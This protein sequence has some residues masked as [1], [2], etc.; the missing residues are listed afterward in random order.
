MGP[1][2]PH[3]DFFFFFFYG[4]LENQLLRC[5]KKK[6]SVSKGQKKMTL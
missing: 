3:L 1:T 6:N 2:L 4:K 5:L